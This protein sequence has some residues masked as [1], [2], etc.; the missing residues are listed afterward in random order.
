[1][2]KMAKFCNN[3]KKKITEKQWKELEPIFGRGLCNVCRDEAAKKVTNPA[4]NL[5]EAFKKEGFKVYL[6]KFDKHKHIDIVLIEH[7]INIEVD[8]KLHIND[9]VS[10]LKDLERSLYSIKAGWFTIHIPNKIATYHAEKAVALIKN[11]LLK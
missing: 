3:C 6:E 5:F 2:N 8:G 4:R 9:S 1:M 10:A 7:K 11:I